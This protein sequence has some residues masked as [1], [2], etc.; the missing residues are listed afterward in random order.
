M[1]TSKSILLERRREDSGS[2]VMTLTLPGKSWRSP[3]T[4]CLPSA[5]L[6]Q[7]YSLCMS[8]IK[9]TALPCLMM[10]ASR[11]RVKKVLPVPLLPKTPLERSTKR[12]RSRC[13]RTFSMSS[14]VPT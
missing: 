10:P 9:L 3:F 2:R 13:T 11:V 5:W 8:K 7:P 4:L 14:G 6:S 1:R 12:P